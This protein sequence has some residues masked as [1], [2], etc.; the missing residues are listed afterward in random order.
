MIFRKSSRGWV[1]LHVASQFE[2]SSS[3]AVTGPFPSGAGRWRG[4]GMHDLIRPSGRNVLKGRRRLRLLRSARHGG[5]L[6]GRRSAPRG[7]A[8]AGGPHCGF[9]EQVLCRPLS[10]PDVLQHHNACREGCSSRVSSAKLVYTSTPGQFP[11]S[12]HSPKL[13]RPLPPRRQDACRPSPCP[14]MPTNTHLPSRP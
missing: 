9:L 6:G 7:G 13:V 14:P 11:L 1:S 3:L 10:R 2:L 4:V 8:G 5:R 12:L